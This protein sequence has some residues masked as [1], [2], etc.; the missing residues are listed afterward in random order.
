VGE[1]V[2]P[3]QSWKS[4][5]ERYH[6]EHYH[7]GS[8]E[9]LHTFDHHE[10]PLR[11]L[12]FRGHGHGWKPSGHSRWQGLVYISKVKYQKEGGKD[13]SQRETGVVDRIYWYDI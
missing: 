7:V 1:V 3:H 10:D 2:K 11:L 12:C 4:R 9:S 5:F 8:G 13:N 6:L